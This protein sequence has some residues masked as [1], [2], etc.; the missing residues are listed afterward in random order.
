VSSW[1]RELDMMAN[2]NEGMPAQ[3]Q[4]P[5]FEVGFIINLHSNSYRYYTPN[6]L[7][8][9]GNISANYSNVREFHLKSLMGSTTHPRRYCNMLKCSQ[10]RR[11]GVLVIEI[12]TTAK[13]LAI[14]HSV[15]MASN[16]Y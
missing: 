14:V 5:Q 1:D 10:T 11:P 12:E 16:Q 8:I 3:C 4:K 13:A 15:V 9:N 7:K 6:R 2:C